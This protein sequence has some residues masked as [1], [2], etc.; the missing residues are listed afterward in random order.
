MKICT[1]DRA[2]LYRFIGEAF[3][4][5]NIV[6]YA[7]EIGVLRGENASDIH[8][9]LKPSK[10]WLIDKWAAVEHFH[11]PFKERP[12][13]IEPEE[14]HDGYFGGPMKNQETFDR[15]FEETTARFG[16]IQEIEILREDS[17]EA[18]H[19]M[20][21][22]LSALPC[23]LLDFIY[24]DADHEYE[25]VLRDLMYWCGLL[26]EDGIIQLN[27]A[28]FSRLGAAQNL[29]VLPAVTEFL[30]R[31]AFTP[32]L[33]TNTDWSDLVLVRTNSNMLATL[34]RIVANSTVGY[35]E[36]PPQLLPAMKVV[37]GAH[38]VNISFL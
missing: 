7:A 2:A 13:Y 20:Q 4:Q 18:F 9:C 37:Y 28:C 22:K 38:R 1:I 19:S 25:Y 36:V 26:S 8:E 15:I 30:K 34:N 6:P 14:S 11:H 31:M 27:D 21:K 17:M 23:S 32:V 33:L 29:G 3:T 10:M 5:L 16:G 35:V 24:L 12:F